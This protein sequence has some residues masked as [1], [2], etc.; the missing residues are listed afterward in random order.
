MRK[1]E[2]T[3]RT[4]EHEKTEKRVREERGTEKENE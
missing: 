1:A 2:A 3:G 4:S